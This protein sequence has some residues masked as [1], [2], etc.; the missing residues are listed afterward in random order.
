MKRFLQFSFGIALIF[1]L[2]GC[3]KQN[4]SYI[5]GSSSNLAPNFTLTDVVTGKPISLDQFKG[6]VVVLNFWATWCGPCREE[7]PSL[8]NIYNQDKNKGLVIIGISMDDTPTPVK[9][10]MEEFNVTY[11]VVMADDAV[12]RAYGGI[13]GIPTTFFIDKSADK[14]VGYHDKKAFED[15]INKLLQ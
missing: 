2:F 9:P 14:F 10:F 4:V 15:E 6:K 11:P 7:I 12:Q 5:R 3:R 1:V 13:D 8:V